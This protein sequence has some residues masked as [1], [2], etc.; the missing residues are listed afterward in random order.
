MR[1]AII[2][3]AAL[4]RQIGEHA[5]TDKGWTITGYYDDRSV[6][7]EFNGAPVLGSTNCVEADYARGRF[8]G[9]MIGIGYNQ[10]AARALHFERLKG[11]VPFAN[12]V[13]SSAYVHSSCKM[14]EGIFLYPGV[15][16]DMAVQLEDNVLIHVGGSVAHDSVIGQHSYLAPG[17]NVAGYATIGRCCFVGI[18]ATIIDEI[19]IAPNSIIG[20]GS[21]IIHN[22]DPNSVSVGVPARQIKKRI[23]RSG[24]QDQVQTN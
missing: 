17:V 23:E 22:T 18:G 9:I 21:V 1:L 12:L 8:D 10:M 16:I 11:R 24:A 15:I 6:G 19:A 5:R 14:G 3:A 7:T 4:G 2:G 20:A 13:H